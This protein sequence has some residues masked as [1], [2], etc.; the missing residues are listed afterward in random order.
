MQALLMLQLALKLKKQ[1]YKVLHV[2]IEMSPIQVP[3]QK[4]LARLKA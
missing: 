3:L 4:V 1:G 2:N